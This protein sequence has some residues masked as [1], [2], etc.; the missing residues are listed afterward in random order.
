MSEK[1]RNTRFEDAVRSYHEPP[2]TPREEIWERIRA[3]RGAAGAERRAP[4]SRG[5]LRRVRT[6]VPAAA[7]AVLLLG[8][9]IGRLTAPAPEEEAR[10]ATVEKKADRGGAAAKGSKG[11]PPSA[12]RR[13]EAF[14][15]AAGPFFG[16]AEILLTD[17]RI[18]PGALEDAGD[19][20]SRAASLLAETRLLL[21]SP[22][23]HD[24]ETAALLRDLELALARLVLVGAADGVDREGIRNGLEEKMLLTR[25][26]ERVPRR[27]R[28]AGI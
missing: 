7:A 10:V 13:A 2:D 11:R 8:V 3:G 28:T 20:P 17:F 5:L 23:A 12:D 15:R 21:D 14:R 18:G 6:W 24:P 16:R 9:G 25:L 4:R 1:G 19:F 27:P 26:R 22:A